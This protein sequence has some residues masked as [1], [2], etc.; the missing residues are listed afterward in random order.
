MN[1]IT[2]DF[3]CVWEREC[4]LAGLCKR[5]EE[6]SGEHHKFFFAPN[7]LGKECP[8]YTPGPRRGQISQ[9]RSIMKDFLLRFGAWVQRT[10]WLDFGLVTAGLV[11]AHLFRD[12]SGL[13]FVFLVLTVWR[14]VAGKLTK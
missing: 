12:F 14:A 13:V 5:V 4:P 2:P 6:A 11:L 7:H 8:Y 3:K 1:E 9:R 10:D